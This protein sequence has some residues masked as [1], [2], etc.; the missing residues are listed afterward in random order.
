M[1]S[2]SSALPKEMV[3]IRLPMP[4]I[5]PQ[6]R[7]SVKIV[8]KRAAFGAL[9]TFAM[10]ATLTVATTPQAFAIAPVPCNRSD[11]L[12]INIHEPYVNLCFAQ[13]GTI[14][15]ESGKWL[16]RISTGNNRVQ[17]HGDGKWQPANPIGKNTIYTFPN[18]PGGVHIDNIRIL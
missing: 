12:W 1:G 13:A 4:Q 6:R 5:T 11:Y 14:S 10:A 2:I 18:H 15:I 16:T 8:T 9:T 17:W 7:I 3:E